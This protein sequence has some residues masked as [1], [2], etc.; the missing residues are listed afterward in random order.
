M[1]DSRR[2]APGVGDDARSLPE[3]RAS[4][5]KQGD[6]QENGGDN[7]LVRSNLPRFNDFIRNVMA[8]LPRQALHARTLGFIHP[9]T[10]E[11]VGFSSELPED[12]TL[13]LEKM[14]KYR[15]AYL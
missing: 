14:R 11:R 6:K 1:F 5:L 13:A 12:M 3:L 9:Q 10:R 2:Q 15:D 8:I 7:I 4:N